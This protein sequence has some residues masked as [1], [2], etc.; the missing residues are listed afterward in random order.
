MVGTDSFKRQA[1][2]WR[3][4]VTVK[5]SDAAYEEIAFM[6]GLGLAIEKPEGQAISYDARIQGPSKKWV[7]KTYALGVRIT[8]EA[9]DDDLYDKMEGVMKELGSSMAETVNV[10]VFDLFNSGGSV[11]TTADGHYVFLATHHRL[12]GSTYSNLYTAASL[13]LDSIQDDIAAYEALRDHRGKIVN[14]T[15][16]V[17][18]IVANPALEWKLAEIFGSTMN[19][20]TSDNAINALKKQ[21]GGLGFITT[22]YITST[23]AR[24]Y[25]GEK[26]PVRGPIFFNRR[27][28]RFAREGDFETGDALFKADVRF[29][30]EVCD[31][32][33]IACNAGA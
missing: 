4:I 27:A 24:F 19:P 28:V 31:P 12:D 5:K 25:I 29:S 20:E 33:N 6:S 15:G 8:E 10:Q 26:D 3:S 2:D 1:E 23:T 9:I 21:R 13:S 14:R 16:S 30:I 32:M 17:K 18:T 7:H 22:P 11:Q